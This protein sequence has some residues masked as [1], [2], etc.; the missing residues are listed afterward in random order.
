MN[1]LNQPPLQF[2]QV[3]GWKVQSWP[4]A[5]HYIIQNMFQWS[6]RG[7]T[8]CQLKG[9]KIYLEEPF[10]YVNFENLA[11]STESGSRKSHQ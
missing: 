6:W 4:S 3:L 2:A 1:V 8:S 10:P 5:S 11:T 7:P 9:L